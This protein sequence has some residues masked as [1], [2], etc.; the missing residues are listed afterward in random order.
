LPGEVSFSVCI[1]T[2]NRPD[3]LRRCL[4]ALAS[5][6]LIADQVIVSDD[7]DDH[8]KVDWLCRQFAFVQYQ[9]G[10]R[11]GLGANRNACLAAVTSSHVIF[12]DDDV[13]T[14]SD[15]LSTAK[16]LCTQ[17]FSA[18]PKSIVSGIEF[19][20]ISTGVVRIEPGNADFWGYQRLPPNGKYESV[21]INATVFPASLFQA[22]KFD[23]LLRYG[24][25]EID[26][27]HHAIACGYHVIFAPEL[28]VDHY[29][30]EI[31]R[32]EYAGVA[33]AS[34]LYATVKSYWSYQKKPW[35]AV[36]FS[37]LAPPKLVLALGRRHGI[38][39]ITS[40]LAA[41]SKATGYVITTIRG[42]Q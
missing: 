22:A 5:S 17:N 26:M 40:A 41:T 31:N 32:G 39:G 35:K 29:P 23:P 37:L 1:C 8:A 10:P 28:F 42:N 6:T 16:D 20:H 13:V 30:S 15:F 4:Q 27:V 24:C 34:R 18:Y 25:E 2:R 19:K 12:F 9:R 38:A 3:D 11:R 36:L 21:V 7:G 14:P 33:E